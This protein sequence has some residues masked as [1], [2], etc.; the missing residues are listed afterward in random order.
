MNEKLKPCPFCG[1][2]A[3]TV[4]R[5]VRSP[6]PFSDYV[7]L[8]VYCSKCKIEKYDDIVDVNFE[9]AERAKQEVIE[10]WNRRSDNV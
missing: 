10:E 4:V 1:G 7:R 6:A 8:K 3:V 5:V 9:A 2:E